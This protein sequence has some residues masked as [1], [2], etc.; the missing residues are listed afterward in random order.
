MARSV[1][2]RCPCGNEFLVP[3]S[4]IAAG[5]GRFCSKDCQRI[6]PKESADYRTLPR[7]ETDPRL[8]GG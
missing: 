4:R 7:E 1:K 2:V 8:D 6:Y 5:H 3:P